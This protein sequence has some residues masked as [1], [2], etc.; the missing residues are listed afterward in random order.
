MSS[1][2]HITHRQ[3]TA[4]AAFLHELRG[5]WDTA[6]IVAQIGY[7]RDLA[8]GPD[9]AIAAIRAAMSA[10]NRTPGVIPL[11]GE[12]W[13]TASSVVTRR[14]L[15]AHERCAICNQG[16]AR[17]E[18]LAALP[19]DGHAFTPAGPRSA[20]VDETTGEVL[21]TRDPGEVLAQVRA[22]L[23]ARKPATT[24]EKELH[25]AQH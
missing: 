6:G 3:A 25:H 8:P 16:Q 11:Q 18:Q 23:A 1:W 22:E 7:A 24:T 21:H 19:D 17:C 15:E 4:L 10:T 12:H 5:D 13:R 20:A 2:P 14:P 9:V